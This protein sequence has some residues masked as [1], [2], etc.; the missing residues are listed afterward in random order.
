MLIGL[1][2]AFLFFG[3]FLIVRQAHLRLPAAHRSEESS[4]SVRVGIAVISTLSALVLG[5]VL[6]S[7]KTNFDDTQRDVRRFGTELVMVDSALRS[8][9]DVGDAPRLQLLEYAR[10]A[11]HGTWPER[12]SDVVVDDRA[13]AKLLQEVERSIVT[14]PH[15]GVVS[16]YYAMRAQQSMSKLIDIRAQIISGSKASLPPIFLAMVVFWF[17]MLFGSFGYRAPENLTV[18]LTTVCSAFAVAS[19]IALMTELDG[20]F[21]GLVTVSSV[22]LR[23]A[24]SILAQS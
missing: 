15:T 5:L 2:S 7:M 10:A 13:A 3:A 12:G 8:I 14:V 11:L 1:V 23:D 21:T 22:P 6:S 20:A 17:T 18:T 4:A 24:I 16:A 9:G 19:A